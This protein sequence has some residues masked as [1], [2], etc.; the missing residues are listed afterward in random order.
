M[1]ALK[2]SYHGKTASSLK[3]T[4]NTTYR[5]PFEGLS[6][7]QPV[8]ID[9][10]RSERLAQVEQEYCCEFYYPEFVDHRVELRPVRATRVMAFIFEPILGEGGIHV[11]PD[12]VLAQLVTPRERIGVPYILDETQTG[13]GRTGS[14]FAFTQ[15]PPRGLE[16][17]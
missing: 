11:V 8:F 17:E 4:F 1:V 2:G 14:L 12:P 10:Q 13:C 7:V 16:P 6:A 9:V 5:E 15:T 3:M